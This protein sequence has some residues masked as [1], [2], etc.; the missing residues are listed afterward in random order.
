MTKIHLSW[1]V[2]SELQIQTIEDHKRAKAQAIEDAANASINR[3][4][5][6][7]MDALVGSGEEFEAAK[8]E[9]REALSAVLRGGG[10]QEE[11]SAQ[12]LNALTAAFIAAG[13]DEETAISK[14]SEALA[15]SQLPELTEAEIAKRAADEESAA[16]AAEGD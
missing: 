3:A 16:A 4:V 5:D 14:A 8:A 1:K 13:D 10:D 7:Q 11:V 15:N 2:V 9:A 12:A 6:A